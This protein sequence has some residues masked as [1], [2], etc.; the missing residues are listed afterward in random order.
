MR[1]ARRHH[2]RKFV[3][4]FAIVPKQA[5]SIG[6]SRLAVALKKEKEPGATTVGL[7]DRTQ[8]VRPLSTF[9][10]VVIR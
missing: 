6:A 5:I 10:G 9:A 4:A 1:Y 3:S 7:A 2:L 8:D